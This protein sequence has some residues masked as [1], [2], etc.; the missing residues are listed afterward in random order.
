VNRRPTQ[1]EGAPLAVHLHG[2]R[3]S[4][5]NTERLTI[6]RR[7]RA[8]PVHGRA[9]SFAATVVDL[10]HMLGAIVVRDRVVD[11][12]RRYRVASASARRSPAKSRRGT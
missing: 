8:D 1:R 2:S 7:E 12:D 5:G 11:G 10:E 6:S 4:T 3:P 9:C